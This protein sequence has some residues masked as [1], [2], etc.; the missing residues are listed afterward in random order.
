M[1]IKNDTTEGEAEKFIKKLE[2]IYKSGLNE[3]AEHF[4]D[5]FFEI[6]KLKYYGD[7]DEFKKRF[8]K[9]YNCKMKVYNLIKV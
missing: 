3:E 1:L 9:V 2:K 7:A 6:C 4:R 5:A 8:R